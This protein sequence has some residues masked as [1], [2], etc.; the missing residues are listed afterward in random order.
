MR[1]TLFRINIHDLWSLDP[2]DGV[3][4]IGA[5]YLLLLGLLIWGGSI[6][7]ER[8]RHPGDGASLGTRLIGPVVAA[9]IVFA[10]SKANIKALENGIP[11]FG[12][13]MMVFLG[14][15]F[16]VWSALGRAR[17]VG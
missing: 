3:T 15:A 9:L 17:A 2:L 13:G 11:V 7:Y 12:Y 1:Q 4:A 14:F 8:W 10:L 6:L 5:G 16:G